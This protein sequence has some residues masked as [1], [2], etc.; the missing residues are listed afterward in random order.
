MRAIFI[1]VN[2]Y[3]FRLF[4]SQVVLQRK[5]AEVFAHRQV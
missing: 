2:D 4:Y 5:Y 3:Y 1:N